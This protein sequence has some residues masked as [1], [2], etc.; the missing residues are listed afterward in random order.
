M[1]TPLVYYDHIGEVY[2]KIT[3]GETMQ[4]CLFDYAKSARKEK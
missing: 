4:K 3:F 1:D 2:E